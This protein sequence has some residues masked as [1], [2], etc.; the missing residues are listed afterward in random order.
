M[1]P[2]PLPKRIASAMTTPEASDGLIAHLDVA[3]GSE[4]K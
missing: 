1:L 3:A 2:M 4:L